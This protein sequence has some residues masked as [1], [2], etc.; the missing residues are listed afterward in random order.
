MP[1]SKDQQVY[2]E[3]N[4]NKIYYFPKWYTPMHIHNFF[5]M[6]SLLADEE[7]K[8]EFC[9]KCSVETEA[10]ENTKDSMVIQ[11]DEGKETRPEQT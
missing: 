8:T 7:K 5:T 11:N 2:I 10:I 4:E 3:H 1:K 9:K 6:Y